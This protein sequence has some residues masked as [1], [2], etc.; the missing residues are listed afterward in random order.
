M[1]V[2]V[3]VIEHRFR[4]AWT[5]TYF[6]PIEHWESLTMENK[7]EVA[8]RLIRKATEQLRAP[9]GGHP[10]SDSELEKECPTLTAFLTYT[11]EPG[12]RV[13]KTAT[14]TV[15]FE[16]GVFKAAMKDRE[17]ERSLWASSDTLAGLWGGLEERLNAEPVEWRR[18][19]GPAWEGKRK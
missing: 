5:R 14:V 11:G 7:S 3:L 15:F 17:E 6:Y 16:D 12:K 19:A 8:A 2:V 13:R 10:C 18:A 9:P 4:R 1:S